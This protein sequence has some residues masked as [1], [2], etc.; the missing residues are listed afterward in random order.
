MLDIVLYAIFLALG[1]LWIGC[2]VATAFLK[3][4]FHAKIRALEV[5]LDAMPDIVFAEAKGDSTLSWASQQVLKEYKGLPGESQTYGDIEGTLRALDTKH[6][7]HL[8]NAHFYLGPEE[9]QNQNGFTTW[10]GGNSWIGVKEGVNIDNGVR[11]DRRHQHHGCIGSEHYALHLAITDI[12]DAIK[13]KEKA[14]ELA[15]VEH[16]LKQVPSLL[17]ALKNEAEANRP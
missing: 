7:R 10:E 12:H 1:G 11:S 2:L 4:R 6:D 14:I 8:L 13:A 5:S 17:E 3:A 9:F 16:E 15:G